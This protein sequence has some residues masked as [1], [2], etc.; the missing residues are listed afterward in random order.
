MLRKIFL[1]MKVVLIAVGLALLA[2][3]VIGLSYFLSIF[4]G[5]LSIVALII[6]IAVAVCSDKEKVT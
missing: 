2:G 6:V 5:A 4:L 3:I 1:F